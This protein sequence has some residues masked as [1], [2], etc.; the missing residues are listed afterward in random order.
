M[1]SA[2]G[3]D[4]LAG[5]AVYKTSTHTSN[6]CAIL[7]EMTY[8]LSCWS[9]ERAAFFRECG[10][11]EIRCIIGGPKDDSSVPCLE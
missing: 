11:P 8:V 7:A 4:T 6:N 5:V 2:S 3:T 10:V 1:A 9:A